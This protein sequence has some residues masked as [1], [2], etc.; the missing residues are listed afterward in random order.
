M[1]SRSL[2]SHQF[3][4]VDASLPTKYGNYVFLSHHVIH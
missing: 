2:Y 4:K 1:T 3:D